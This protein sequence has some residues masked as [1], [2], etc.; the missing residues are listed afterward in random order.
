MA[1]F[2]CFSLFVFIATFIVHRLFWPSV[3]SLLT[4]KGQMEVF[5][6]LEEK[7]HMAGFLSVRGVQ[8]WPGVTK[9]MEL[10]GGSRRTHV[11][12]W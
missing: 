9:K 3:G 8:I 6:E 2:T 5:L 7:K 10:Q 1:A 12:P 4:P 11:R